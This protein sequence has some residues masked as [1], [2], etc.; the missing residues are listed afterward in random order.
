MK[1]STATVLSVTFSDALLF[2]VGSDSGSGGILPVTGSSPPR[3]SN[4]LLSLSAV[5]DVVAPPREGNAKDDVVTDAGILTS[6][7]LQAVAPTCTAGYVDCVNGNVRG[8]TTSCVAA[9]AGN[10]CVGTNACVELTGQVCKDGSCNANYACYKAHLSFVVSSCI[11]IRACLIAGGNDGTVGSIVNS[12][13][14]NDSCGYLGGNGGVVGNIQDS[15]TQYGSCVF[16]GYRGTVGNIQHSCNSTKSCVGVGSYEGSIG[17][18]TS[19]CNSYKACYAAGRYTA[20]AISSSLDDCCNTDSAC[21]YYSEAQ[22]AAN[23]T[24]VCSVSEQRLNI[25]PN[26]SIIR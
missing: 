14:V 12:C 20:S 10:C 5:D 24:A 21:D 19:S 8:T 22:L 3:I 9:C 13:T 11:G 6:R 23:R 25:L 17:S 26:A 2:L 7:V 4:V 15:C 16:T 1:F 18:I